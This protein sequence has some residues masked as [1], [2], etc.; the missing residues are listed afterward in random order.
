MNWYKTANLDAKIGDDDYEVGELGEQDFY[1][2]AKMT[3]ELAEIATKEQERWRDAY[4][5]AY[6]AGGAD[7]QKKMKHA[8]K[9]VIKWSKILSLIWRKDKKTIEDMIE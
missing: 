6:D 7:Y 1:T 4:G 2:D 9:M 5:R 8:E 3:T